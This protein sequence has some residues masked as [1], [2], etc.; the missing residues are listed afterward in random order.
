MA[1][2]IRLEGVLQSWGILSNGRSLDTAEFPTKSA[3]VGLLG[4]A[5]GWERGNPAD[6]AA[7]RLTVRRDRTGTVLVDYQTTDFGGLNKMVTNAHYLMDASFLAILE[8][9]PELLETC[10]E[11]LWEPVWAPCLGRR[12]CI[13]TIPLAQGLDQRPLAEILS[14]PATLPQRS[15]MRKGADSHKFAYLTEATIA[16]R[17]AVKHTDVPLSTLSDYRKFGPRFVKRSS[18]LIQNPDATITP[19][20]DHDPM[21]MGSL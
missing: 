8:G 6:L 21:E 12:S 19:A 13:P 3:V 11:A 2:L 20:D 5:L 16:D 7:L 17:G 1:L 9:D 4:S 18:V 14:D 10:H 15:D